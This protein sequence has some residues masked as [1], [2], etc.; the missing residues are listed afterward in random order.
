MIAQGVSHYLVRCYILGLRIVWIWIYPSYS[1]L[2]MRL[3]RLSK[4]RYSIA[5]KGAKIVAIT[6]DAKNE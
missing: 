5:I 4:S 1:F 2:S 3:K 6:A